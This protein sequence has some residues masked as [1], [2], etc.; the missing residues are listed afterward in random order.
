MNREF[1]RAREYI[2]VAKAISGR[3]GEIRDALGEN[4]YATASELLPYPTN[5]IEAFSGDLNASE[6][7]MYGPLL[8]KLRRD[9]RDVLPELKRLERITLAEESAA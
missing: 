8:D 2:V 1:Q 3:L 4:N 9:L 7:E 5:L 6:K